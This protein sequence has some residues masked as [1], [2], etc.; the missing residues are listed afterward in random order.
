M[1]GLQ[2][3]SCG[4]PHGNNAEILKCVC[5]TE[6]CRIYVTDH[7]PSHFVTVLSVM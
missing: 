1:G 2:P 4:L 6:K 3:V 5:G 7:S